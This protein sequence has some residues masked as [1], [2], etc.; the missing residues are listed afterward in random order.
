[1]CVSGHVKS[2]LSSVGTSKRYKVFRHHLNSKID[3]TATKYP[4]SSILRTVRSCM[5]LGSAMY[6]Y[7]DCLYHNDHG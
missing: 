2:F 4:Q 5:W 7:S 1:M 3:I 6:D